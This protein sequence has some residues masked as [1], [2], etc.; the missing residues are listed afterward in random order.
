MRVILDAAIVC[1]A[2][3]AAV[4]GAVSVVTLLQLGARLAGLLE[5]KGH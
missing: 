3:L 2:A 1:T 5:R 4:M